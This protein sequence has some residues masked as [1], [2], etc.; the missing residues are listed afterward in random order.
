MM[1]ETQRHTGYFLRLITEYIRQLVGE[2]ISETMN[3]T[4]PNIK[5]QLTPKN[6][7]NGFDLMVMKYEAVI[8]F[9]AFPFK[10]FDPA[11]LFASIGAWLMDN[12]P[13]RNKFELPDPDVKTVIED[14]SSAQVFITINFHEP[15]MVEEDENGLIQWSG[16]RY[17]I[18][19]YEIW[20]AEH[21]DFDV[22]KN[23]KGISR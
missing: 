12:D 13:Y 7:G 10:T 20:V 14:E 16:K 11:V 4:M 17:S 21:F 8:H 19:P 22:S 5:L 6:M 15:V 1:E 18:A 9:E 2:G 3:S 23:V